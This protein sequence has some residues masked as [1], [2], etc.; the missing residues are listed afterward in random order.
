[1]GTGNTHPNAQLTPEP[2]VGMAIPSLAQEAGIWQ[3]GLHVKSNMRERARR[4]RHHSWSHSEI[5][6]E[7][8]LNGAVWYNHSFCSE[9]VLWCTE[10][11]VNM[12]QSYG[13]LMHL[14]SSPKGISGAI[15]ELRKTGTL[16]V[17]AQC[18]KAWP[19]FCFRHAAIN[20]Y[21]LVRFILIMIHLFCSCMVQS[22]LYCVCM[23]AHMHT[24]AHRSTPKFSID[25]STS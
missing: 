14:H 20:Y 10:S 13:A 5:S 25:I 18:Q 16:A 12:C 19:F 3:R 15:L 2:L 11:S 7:D 6:D 24:H 21:H 1:M 8:L 22:P 9:Y 23:H 17:R 4:P